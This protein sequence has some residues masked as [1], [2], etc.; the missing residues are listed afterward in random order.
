MGEAQKIRGGLLS[1]FLLPLWSR[2]L[3]TSREEA[4]LRLRRPA[5]RSDSRLAEGIDVGLASV[6]FLVAQIVQR[7]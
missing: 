1:G 7:R 6:N 2:S 3:S 5:R 4:R